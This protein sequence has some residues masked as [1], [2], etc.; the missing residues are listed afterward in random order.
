MLL[1]RRTGNVVQVGL[2]HS[3]T[4]LVDA[5]I[6]YLLPNGDSASFVSLLTNLE[7]ILS[8]WE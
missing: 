4:P 2:R 5:S 8:C 6:A 1:G 3:L 7:L